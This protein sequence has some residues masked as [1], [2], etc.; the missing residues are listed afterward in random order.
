MLLSLLGAGLLGCFDRQGAEPQ[1]LPQAEPVVLGWRLVPGEHLAYSLTSTWTS[2]GQVHSRLEHWDYAVSS[3]DQDRSLL[4]GRLQALGAE[5]L[6]EGE[7]STLGLDEAREA[8]KARLATPVELTLAMDGRLV[9]LRGAGWADAL[10]HRLLALQ[11]DHG[12]VEPG[13]RWPDPVVAR[14]YA[15]LLPPQV[16][17]VVEGYETFEGLFEIDGR[18]YARIA[19]RGAVRPVEPSVPGVWISG[20]AWWDVQAGQLDRRELRV[21]LDDE[22]EPGVLELAIERLPI[23]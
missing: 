22:G 19:T 5:V 17:V 9:E 16:D 20:E 3:L 4:R 21:T 6:L 11:L 12:A 13:T 14:P 1:P 8:E 2:D 23:R 10:P 15:E 7:P 18:I